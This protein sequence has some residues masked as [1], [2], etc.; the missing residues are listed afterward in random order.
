MSNL[1]H[2]K[3]LTEVYDGL[4]AA[5]SEEVRYAGAGG[6]APAT[7]VA[8]QLPV[9]TRRDT[10][11]SSGYDPALRVRCHTEHPKGRAK[12]VDA[13]GLAE[14]VQDA[15][16]SLSISLGPDHALLDLSNPNVTESSYDMDAGRAALDIILEYDLMTQHI[17]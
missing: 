17:A 13:F 16:E 6:E 8:L 10:L 5:L 11:T 7:Y 2:K 9:A 4:T 14:T 12:P 1:P 3:I 15:M